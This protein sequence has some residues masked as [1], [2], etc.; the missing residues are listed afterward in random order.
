MRRFINGYKKNA[1]IGSD[2]IGPEVNDEGIKVM[3]KAAEIYGDIAFEY[4]H[5]HLQSQL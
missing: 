5:T 2:G 3:D 4:I 1:V